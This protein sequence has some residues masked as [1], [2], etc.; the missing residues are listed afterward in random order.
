VNHTNNIIPQ[1]LLLALGSL[2]TMLFACKKPIE[3]SENNTRSFLYLDTLTTI[4]VNNP[5]TVKKVYLGKKL[6]FDPL[7][8]KKGD[9]S[10]ATCHEPKLAFT[11]GVSLSTMGT[12]QKRLDRNS[13]A[14]FNLAW[15]KDFFW[16]G[17]KTSLENQAFGPL[18]NENE[19]AIDLDTLM[20]RLHAHQ[21]YP[22]LFKKTFAN[23]LQIE[24]VVKAIASYERTLISF[25]SKYD[26]YKKGKIEFT[27]FEKSGE[28]VF[29]TNCS[30]CHKP[31]LF[32]DTKF[33]NNGIDGT[34]DKVFTHHS[35]AKYRIS[36]DIKDQGKYKTPSLR[37][38]DF[39]APYM[40]DGRFTSLEEILLHYEN[41]KISHS[42]DEQLKNG[43]H[44]TGDEKNNLLIFLNTLND[45][46]FINNFEQ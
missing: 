46:S 43:I 16:D 38:L 41:P 27:S 7:L 18:R 10:C 33:H 42:L 11:D 34:I 32:T 14:I 29:N 31:P 17:G 35:Q 39:T 30:A 6:F 40:H 1:Y 23:G 28:Q 8:S 24:N 26:E 22:D 36:G 3:K 5:I 45:S 9:I 2:A 25:S 20:V 15:H 21:T 44:L 12:S 37:N 19:M 13:P 4:P